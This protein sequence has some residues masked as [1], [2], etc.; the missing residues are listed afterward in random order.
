MSNVD[1]GV[2]KIQRHYNNNIKSDGTTNY[3]QTN[4][5]S[6][7]KSRA[8]KKSFAHLTNHIANTSMLCY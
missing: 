2:P 8:V 5:E 1:I 6:H 4:S 3:G 7:H